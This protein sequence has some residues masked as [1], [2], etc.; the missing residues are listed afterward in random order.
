MK[1]FIIKLVSMIVAVIL[2]CITIVALSPKDNT[3]YLDSIIGKHTL[4]KDVKSP[5]I[6]FIGGSNLAFGLDSERVQYKLDIPVINM[7]LHA[8]LG[9]RFML[10]DLESY[11]CKGDII[12]LIPE[13]DHFYDRT[14]EGDGGVQW[15]VISDVPEDI[16]YLNKNQFDSV[17][18]AIISSLLPNFITEIHGNIRNF[19]KN[20]QTKELKRTEVY[21]RYAFNKKGDVINHIGLKSTSN[22]IR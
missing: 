9:L 18:N 4:L 10:S 6:I 16:R 7:G 5:K 21:S 19:K 22:I 13:Y 2:T 14:L 20:T 8:G 3:G 17:I 15:S 11:I 1:K 12:V